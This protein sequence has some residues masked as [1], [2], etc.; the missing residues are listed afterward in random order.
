MKDIWKEQR[1]KKFMKQEPVEYRGGPVY[2]EDFD[3]YHG[4]LDELIDYRWDDSESYEDAMVFECTIEK[5]TTPN[6]VECVE[7]RWSEEFDHDG[8]YPELPTEIRV[9]LDALQEDI[10]AA[11]PD[12]WYPDYKRRL[13]FDYSGYPDREENE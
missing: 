4:T 9:K 11:A 2:D 10:E 13:T 12:V 7:E 3:R 6:L 1:R 8:N 5:A